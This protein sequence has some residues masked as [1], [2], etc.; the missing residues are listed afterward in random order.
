MIANSF[1]L[2]LAKNKSNGRS[3]NEHWFSIVNIH[4]ILLEQHFYVVDFFINLNG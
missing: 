1:S 3:K 2:I 4:V